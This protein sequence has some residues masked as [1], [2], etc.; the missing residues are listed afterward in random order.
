M[1]IENSGKQPEPKN[2]EPISM[3]NIPLALGCIL[4]DVSQIKPMVTLLSQHLGIGSAGTKRV[5]IKEAALFLS[6]TERA[7]RKMVKERTIP[8]YVRNGILYFFE[9][10]LLEWV[11]GNRVATFEE[12]F[13]LNR[14]HSRR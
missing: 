6:V 4:D 3:A 12:E 13:K 8:Y 2:P 1:S 10:E 14:R 5:T 9:K 11:K 7:I